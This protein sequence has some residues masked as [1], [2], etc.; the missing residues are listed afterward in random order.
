MEAMASGTMI[1]CSDIRGNRDLI[2][3]GYNGYL[4]G[5]NDVERLKLLI[6][7]VS[8]MDESERVDYFNRNK[9]R[10]KKYD[11]NRIIDRMYD[12]YGIKS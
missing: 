11:V 7:S 8:K 10:I 4:F 12:I 9:E 6:E 3:D 2:E 1:I 5:K